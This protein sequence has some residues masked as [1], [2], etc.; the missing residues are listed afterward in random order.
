MSGE[1]PARLAAK[2]L[3]PLPRKLLVRDFLHRQGRVVG[4]EET[5]Y[6]A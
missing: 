3:D 6:L 1:R 2:S 5:L 4:F